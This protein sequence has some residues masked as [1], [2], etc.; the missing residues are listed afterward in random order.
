M[1]KNMLV[2]QYWVILEQVSFSFSLKKRTSPAFLHN[3]VLVWLLTVEGTFILAIMRWGMQRFEPPKVCLVQPVLLVQMTAGFQ[4][5]QIGFPFAPY[6][7]L[8]QKNINYTKMHQ[9]MTQKLQLY[10]D[11]MQTS[12]HKTKSF[13]MLQKCYL[14]N[15][16]FLRNKL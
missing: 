8:F 16:D 6:L 9:S 10:I 3:G 4:L 7:N 1:Q 2:T 14:G 13:K 15:K 12:N 5:E 11:K